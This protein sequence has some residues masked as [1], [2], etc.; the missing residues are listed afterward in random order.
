VFICIGT[1]L[2][3]QQFHIERE[4]E[5]I[6][7]ANGTASRILYGVSSSIGCDSFISTLP[8]S[9]IQR[10][11]EAAKKSK[12]DLGR[13]LCDMRCKVIGIRDPPLLLP[14][15]T[16]A[17]AHNVFHSLVCICELENK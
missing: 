13:F 16:Y 5:Y 15:G 2:N 9:N 6:D 14:N 7:Y 1:A 3:N 17:Q 11:Y 8:L 12:K 4:K 10:M